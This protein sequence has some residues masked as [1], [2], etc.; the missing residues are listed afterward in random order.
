[1]LRY[2]LIAVLLGGVFGHKEFTEES[3]NSSSSH[4]KTAPKKKKQNKCLKNK[5]GLKKLEN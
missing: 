1:M 4:N 5:Y 2:V 3:Q